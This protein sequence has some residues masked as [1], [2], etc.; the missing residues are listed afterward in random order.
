MSELFN[1]R[2][3]IEVSEEMRLLN[4]TVFSRRGGVETSINGEQVVERQSR[5]RVV[6]DTKTMQQTLLMLELVKAGELHIEARY[7]YSFGLNLQRPFDK[8]PVL[9]NGRCRLRPKE[10]VVILEAIV[11]LCDAML[12][13]GSVVVGRGE[14]KGLTSM[15]LS[16]EMAGTCV[17]GCL[18][19]CSSPEDELFFV[20]DALLAALLWLGSAPGALQQS[21]REQ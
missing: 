5:L 8:I 16:S 18:D 11:E 14:A 7:P 6:L 3:G 12:A 15:G 17:S 1:A 10:W 21:K 2:V 19:P 20:V 13:I 4:G 9:S